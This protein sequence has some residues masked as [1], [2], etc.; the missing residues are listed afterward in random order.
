MV[1]YGLGRAVMKLNKNKKTNLCNLTI[2][3]QFECGIIDTSNKG[4]HY[5][6]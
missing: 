1:N 2:D 3:F 5:N 4:G 6:G